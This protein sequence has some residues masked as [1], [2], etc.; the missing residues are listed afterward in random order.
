MNNHS[1]T[2]DIAGCII[3]CFSFVVEI[4]NWDLCES[5]LTIIKKLNKKNLL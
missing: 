1:Q 2:Q 3:R 4:N 5:V